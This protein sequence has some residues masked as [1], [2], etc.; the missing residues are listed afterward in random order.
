[1]ARLRIQGVA[2]RRSQDIAVEGRARVEVVDSEEAGGY[3]D[4]G[5]E[6]AGPEAGGL[7]R[8]G[9][10]ERAVSERDEVS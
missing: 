7:G 9:G 5:G 6:G 2:Q 10:G 8:G 1:M 4:N 3:G